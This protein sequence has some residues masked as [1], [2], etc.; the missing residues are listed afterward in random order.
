MPWHPKLA[1]P[2]SGTCKLGAIVSCWGIPRGRAYGRAHWEASPPA[3]KHQSAPASLAMKYVVIDER[4]TMEQGLLMSPPHGGCHGN[5]AMAGRAKGGGW[6][7][8][9]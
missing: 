3:W 6:E 5:R 4:H 1:T 2:D 8:K 9:T 7:R